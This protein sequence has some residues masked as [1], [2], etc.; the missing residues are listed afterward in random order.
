MTTEPTMVRS[1]RVLVQGVLLGRLRFL[2]QG[3]DGACGGDDRVVQGLLRVGAARQRV[4]DRLVGDA[5]RG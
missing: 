1:R 4:Q 5:G 3:V 2:R